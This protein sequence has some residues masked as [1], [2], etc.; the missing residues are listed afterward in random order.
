MWEEQLEWFLVYCQRQR[1]MQIFWQHIFL[2]ELWTLLLITFKGL[3][4]QYTD[5]NRNK[6]SCTSY[7][8][9]LKRQVY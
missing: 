5:I 1:T 9:A 3:Y 7:C 6:K 8:N 4:I 2:M